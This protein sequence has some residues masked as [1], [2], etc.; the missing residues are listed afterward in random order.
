[1]P[2]AVRSRSGISSARRR[3]TLPRLE[4]NSRWACAVV[5]IDVAHEVVGLELGA[6]D[7]AAAART[8][9]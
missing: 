9:S 5:K 1:M 2:L 8:G 3:Y 6:A 4:K 7:A